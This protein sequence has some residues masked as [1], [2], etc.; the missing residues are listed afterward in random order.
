MRV[1]VF[2]RVVVT[3]ALV[4]AALSLPARTWAQYF[5]QNKVRYEDFT[6]TVME[7]ERFDIYHYARERDAVEEAARLAERWYSRL[8]KVLDHDLRGRQPLI[9]YASH[10]DFAQT[11]VVRGFI[12]EGTGGVTELLKRRM[13]LP[14]TA[15][16]ADTSHVLGHEMVHA[17]QFDM[18]GRNAVRLPLWFIEGMAEYLSLGPVHAQTA[19]WLRDAAL[20]EELPAFTDLSDPEFFPYRYGHAAW[21][22][23]AGRFGDAIVP[24]LYVKASKSGDA[25]AAIESLTGADIKTLS[26]EWHQA[27]ERSFPS[28]STKA[29]DSA[30]KMLISDE[31]D[32]G[33]I[34]VSPALSPDGRWIVFLSERDLFSFDM[35]LADA[36]TGEIVRKLT[37]T[38]TDPHFDSLQFIGSAGAWDPT[39]RRFAFTAVSKGRPTLNVLDTAQGDAVREI[40]L[41][42]LGEAFHPTWSPNGQTIA[43]AAIAGGV[44]D[45]YAYDLASE[46]RRRLTNDLYSELQPAWS[47]AGDAIAFVTDR[48]TT[49]MEILDFGAY[50]LALYDVASGRVAP[51]PDFE[52]GKN[53][54]PQ[55]DAGGNGLYFVGDPEGIPNVY[56]LDRAARRIEQVTDVA[57]GVT[58]ITELSPAVSYAPGAN[59]LAY[60]VFE[61]GH[62]A[63]YALDT[64][65]HVASAPEASTP[66]QPAAV[67]PP[68]DQPGGLVAQVLQ[69]AEIGLPES[70]NFPVSEYDADLSLDQVGAAAGV[71]GGLGRF[72]MFASGGISLLFSDILGN[73]TVATTAQLNGR[74]GDFAG[75]MAYLNQ[76]SRWGWGGAVQQIPYRT[77]RFSQSVREID[78]RPVFVEQELLSRQTDREFQ[79]FTQYPFS[80]AR[81]LEFRG[82]FRNISFSRELTTRVF[83]L[84]TGQFLGDQVEDLPAQ[85]SLHLAEAGAALVYDTSIFGATSPVL[86]RRSRF[87]ITP[88]F[89]S[90]QFTEA[91]VDY[92]HYLSLGRPFTLALRGVHFGRYGQ[93]AEDT[94]LSPLFVG[95]PTLVRGYDIGSFDFTECVPDATSSCPAIDNLLGSR[96]LV[97]NAEV[98]FPLVGAFKGEFDY[99]PVP[100]EGFIF[101]DTGVAWTSA[102]DPSF[103]GGSRDFV[104]SVGVG[105][106]VNALG[107]LILE[108]AAA[109][110]LDRRGRGWLF[111]FQL[112]P[113]F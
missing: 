31:Q 52:N 29:V 51:L 14:F 74:L 35:F 103:A 13:V 106:R 17:F 32:G 24:A 108:F 75:Q 53:I 34:N 86:G 96:L 59:R 40:V 50:R 72:G 7:T 111:A 26:Q 100:V 20:R 81:R 92:R 80:R 61:D 82:G 38:A 63:I 42:G 84:E 95:Y 89:G 65:Q 54:N 45:L 109:K 57:T 43:F 47:P 6:F 5:G 37:D 73:H 2:R 39:S 69:Q 97:G 21:A 70:T 91:L 9:L 71:S 28:T 110:P 76:E 3:A 85:D 60:S 46:Q 49:D 83:S 68:R 56:R 104:T 94:R 48:F 33:R 55:W 36:A 1:K 22:Y 44:S 12:G 88:T 15:S 19:L 93:D 101:A 27:V 62:Y 107:Y 112:T 41:E 16:L 10:P 67:L 99:G 66:G 102:I 23:L 4:L 90:L 25:I 18:A 64:S 78:G 98:R 77:G 105:A 11:N 58:G 79:S 8:S 87:E 113:G 30:G